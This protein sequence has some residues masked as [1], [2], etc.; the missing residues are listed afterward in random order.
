MRLLQIVCRAC[1][2]EY[3]ESTPKPCSPRR[4]LGCIYEVFYQGRRVLS[5]CLSVKNHERQKKDPS[6]C[7]ATFHNKQMCPTE[8]WPYGN[9]RV[10]VLPSKALHFFCVAVDHWLK[11]HVLTPI[12]SYSDKTTARSECI[13][14]PL[15][16]VLVGKISL[17]FAT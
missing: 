5:T 12:W 2:A 13:S 3:Q 9:G 15:W 8:L 14:I 7:F 6:N 16:V 1:R 17:L 4:N 11:D 10:R